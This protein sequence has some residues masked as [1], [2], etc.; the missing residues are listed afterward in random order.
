[1]TFVISRF[2]LKK[3]MTHCLPSVLSFPPL[4][5]STFFTKSYTAVWLIGSPSA[6]CLTI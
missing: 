6:A 3:Y 2:R 5:S 1:M 4:F